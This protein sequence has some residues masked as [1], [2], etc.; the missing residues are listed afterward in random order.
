ML[1]LMS[2]EITKQRQGAENRGHHLFPL[3]FPIL[4]STPSPSHS[5]P[6]HYSLFRSP[7]RPL[8]FLPP[9]IFKLNEKIKIKQKK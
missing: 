6:Y 3:S 5:S 2:E 1:L 8:P 4:S 7:F 9:P